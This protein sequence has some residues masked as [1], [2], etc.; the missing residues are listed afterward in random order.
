MKRHVSQA[1]AA[2]GQSYSSVSFARWAMA[3]QVGG[4]R[5]VGMKTPLRMDAYGPVS[6]IVA[7]L[8]EDR[9][10]LQ[11]GLVGAG[12]GPADWYGG[13]EFGEVE[14]GMILVGAWGNAP[15]CAFPDFDETRELFRSLW[16]RPLPYSRSSRG[17]SSQR[18]ASSM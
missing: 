17:E 16:P 5:C 9:D 4:D 14:R 15:E 18:S 1:Q 11:D 8:E 10:D 7:V 13:I 3:D 2:D 12:P 6:W